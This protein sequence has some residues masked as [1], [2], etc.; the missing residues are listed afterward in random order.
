MINTRGEIKRQAKSAGAGQ[1]QP[2]DIIAYGFAEVGSM[3]EI[4]LVFRF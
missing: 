3:R 1:P 2:K 4:V